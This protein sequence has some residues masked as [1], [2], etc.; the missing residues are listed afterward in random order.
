MTFLLY[1]VPLDNGNATLNLFKTLAEKSTVDPVKCAHQQLA[2]KEVIKQHQ[3]R[4]NRGYEHTISSQDKA[5]MQAILEFTHDMGGKKAALLPKKIDG[6]W[7]A[8]TKVFAS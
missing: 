6:C 8:L 2:V 5:H 3:D 7:K 1:D 4:Q